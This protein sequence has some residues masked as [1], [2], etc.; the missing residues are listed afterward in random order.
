VTSQYEWEGDAIV[1]RRQVGEEHTLGLKAEAVRQERS[2]VHARVSIALDGI[3]LAWGQ[4][5]IERDEDR[6]RL[7]NSAYNLLKS[8]NGSYPKEYLKKDLD[9]FCIGL[10]DEHNRQYQ[11]EE[12]AGNAEPRAPEFM[13]NPY[14]L[15]GGGTILYAPPGRGKSY[16]LFLMAASLHNG[17]SSLWPTRKC[18]PLVINLERSKRS[19]QDRLGNVNRVLGLAPETPLPIINARG[20]SL[21][22]VMPA[23]RRYVKERGIDCILLDS[24]SRA[25]FGD[26]T[27]NAPVNR[28]VDALNSLCDT[29]L[30]LG[31]TPR[32][33]DSHLYGSVHFDAGAD[34]LVQL[35]S[36][37]DETG[38]LG[39]GLQLIKRNDVAWQPL[40]ILALEFSVTGLQTVRHARRGEFPQIE[41]DQK[42]SLKQE[43]LDYI[44]DA[45]TAS[46]SAA[47]KDLKRN[48]TNV[49]HLLANDPAFIPTGRDGHKQLYGVR[50][51]DF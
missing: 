28:I 29:W 45:G 39:I 34:L 38:P 6:V 47:A 51:L 16:T 40:S 43:L 44:L 10:W 50:N 32:G 31:H 25:G 23:A 48:R 1:S 37:Q 18:R 24:I 36:Q 5:N 3:A 13:V 7:G 2:G 46:A 14:L 26:L 4:H 15:Q 30:A 41:Q 8:L 19:V 27:E 17:V 35:L 42:R 20:R 33:D 9:L 22:D 12:M 49:A 21:S 11:P